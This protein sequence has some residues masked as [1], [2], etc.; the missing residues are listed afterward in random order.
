[1]RQILRA[2]SRAMILSA[3]WPNHR[4]GQRHQHRDIDR[5][6]AGGELRPTLF[7]YVV[8]DGTDPLFPIRCGRPHLRRALDARGNLCRW[9]G[10]RQ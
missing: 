5:G 1:M 7:H 2:V 8:P 6:V 10:F 9:V 4:R 3:S